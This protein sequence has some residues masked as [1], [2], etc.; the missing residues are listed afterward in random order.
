MAFQSQVER[1]EFFFCF[2]KIWPLNAIH[3]MVVTV[4]KPVWRVSYRPV[5]WGQCVFQGEK[6]GVTVRRV[7][8]RLRGHPFCHEVERKGSQTQY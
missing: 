1:V 8:G 6:G 7:I 2:L 3:P 4:V 5:P